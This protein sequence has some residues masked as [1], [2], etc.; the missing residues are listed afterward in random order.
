VAKKATDQASRRGTNTAVILLVGAL[1]GLG[2]LVVGGAVGFTLGR[3]K[4]EA[5]VGAGERAFMGVGVM[6]ID[7]GALIHTLYP[8]GP[9]EEAGL[10][11]GDIIARVDGEPVWRES[12]L[13]PILL[14]HEPGDVVRVSVI[15]GGS[16]ERFDVTL[17]ATPSDLE[18]ELVPER[19][20]LPGSPEF[21]AGATP[22][23]GVVVGDEEE[24]GVL[25]AEVLPGSPAEE[26]GLREG[27]VILSANGEPADTLEQL[28]DLILEAGVGGHLEMEILRDGER[29]EVV[30]VL[31]SESPPGLP[32]F[33]S[34]AAFLGVTVETFTSEMAG[35]LELPYE[36]GVLILGVE[37]DSPAARVGLRERDVIV[38]A[39][40][41]RVRDAPEFVELVH[42]HNPGDVLALIVLREGEERAFEVALGARPMMPFD[43][44]PGAFS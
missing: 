37:P 29:R 7:E 11:V 35:D 1:I 31:G 20:P 15:R 5:E 23:L 26:A 16:R 40:D 28:R 17:G 2:G 30:A 27:D 19:V 43:V 4:T 36:P 25:V 34:E 39:N 38:S 9:A 8:D 41:H 18:R 6:Y 42:A 14:A 3:L 33:P 32:D 10:L 13:E 12:P 24:G 44:E 22:F 21:P